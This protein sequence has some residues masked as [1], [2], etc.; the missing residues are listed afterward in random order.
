MK[1]V[2]SK[3]KV[4]IPILIVFG[5]LAGCTSH[6]D[7][8]QIKALEEAKA[9]ALSAE[10]TLASKKTEASTLESQCEAKKAELEKVKKEKELVLQRLEEKKKAVM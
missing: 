8:E 3:F 7:E 1:L 4:V 9:A 5:W 6:P 10:Q 2:L